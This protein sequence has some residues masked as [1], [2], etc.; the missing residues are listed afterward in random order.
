MVESFKEKGVRRMAKGRPR[1]DF[2]SLNCKLDAEIAESLSSY[3]ATSGLSK[4]TVVER[5][6][7]SYLKTQEQSNLI[8]LNKMIED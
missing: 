5:A 7:V 2:V 8:R 4:T 6:L 1:K 3:C